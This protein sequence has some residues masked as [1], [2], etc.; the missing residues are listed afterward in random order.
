MKFVTF[1]VCFLFPVKLSF[2]LLNVLG[3]K[4]HSGS[5]IG[6]SFLWVS[7]KIVLEEGARVGHFNFIKIDHLQIGKEGYIGKYNK[8]TGPVDIILE[9]TAAIGN[10]NKLYRAPLGVTYGKAILKLGILSKITG[11]HR[12]DCTRS[13]TMGNYSILAGHNSQLWTHSYTH[14]KEG[15]GRFRVDGEIGIG[16]NV[17]IGSMSV[18]NAGVEIADKIVVGSNSS[19]SKS[20]L[21][22]GTYVSQPL[23]FIPFDPLA[24]PQKKYQKVEGYSICEDV[25]EKK[26]GN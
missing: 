17:Y 12:I 18:I 23:R 7:G 24:D 5:R 19:V 13:I 20:L 16:N 6:F 8:I 21:E 26:S 22:Q 11:N 25:Y 14:D 9:S 15:P 1:I 3:H 2:W 4:I 10:S